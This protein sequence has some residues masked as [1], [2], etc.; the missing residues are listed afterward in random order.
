MRCNFL[1]AVLFCAAV[2]TQAQTISVEPIK[3]GLDLPIGITNADDGSGRLFLNLQRGKIV[4]WNGSALLATPYL[5]IVAKVS[6][7]GER[8]LLGVAFHPLYRNNGR[9]FVSYTDSN[10][11]TVL[12]RYNVLAGDANRADPASEL[13]LLTVAQP[14]SNH[15]GGQI[16][17][18]PDGYL[19]VSL[20]DGGAAGD[21]GNRA[22]NPEELLGKMLRID[23]DRADPGKNYAIPA[24]NPYV[25]TNPFPGRTPRKEIWALGLRNAWSF[26]FDRQTGDLYIGDVG[27]GD[28]EEIDFQ[29]AASRGGENYGWRIMEGLNCFDPPSGCNKSGLT[30]PILQYDHGLGCSVTGGR[31][32]RG[33]RYPGLAGTYL[34]GDFCSGRI[35]GGKRNAGVWSS[36]QL[37]DTSLNIVAWG[38]DES[39]E[40]YVI[41]HGDESSANGALYRVVSDSVSES[42][43]DNAPAGVA[44]ASRTFTGSWCKSGATGF[45]GVDSLYSCG[46]VPAGQNTYRWIPNVPAAGRYDVFVRWTQNPNR[47]TNVPF[48]V[49]HAEGTSSANFN[50]RIGGGQW[51]FMGNFRFLA[52]TGGYVQTDDRNGQANADA[53]RLVPAAGPSVATLRVSVSGSGSG[54]VTSTPAGIDCGADCAQDY[55]LNTVV[56]LSAT[57]DPGSDFVEWGGPCAGNGPCTVTMND[58]KFLAATF[59]SPAIIIDNALRNRQDPAGGRTYTGVWCTSIGTGYFGTRSLASCGTGVETYRWTPNIP[60]AGAFDVYVRWTNNPQRAANVPY[61][62]VHAGG[63]DTKSFDQRVGGGAWV[64]LGR[65]S[66]AAGT[67]GYVEVSDVNGQAC[68][69]AVQLVPA[70]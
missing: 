9:F 32:Y 48:T 51:Q 12:S 34:Y 40:L 43:V 54:R 62:V 3:T 37:L 53:V 49:A 1:F 2:S 8:G 31:V 68:A 69:D 46:T 61:K 16:R 66:F 36:S 28:L 56:T 38:E 4:I 35:W 30:L 44:D 52:G 41:H 19:Y 17:F 22:Q 20:G 59:R 21:P 24:S 29:A 50:E 45:F 55:A 14:F 13:V 27:Q 63:S 67:A 15:N 65:Y 5:D 64:L 58:S 33:T 60:S 11:N 25:N 70:F 26:S 6:C 7:C 18:G 57:P 10:G 42:V 39:G 23:V 47:S